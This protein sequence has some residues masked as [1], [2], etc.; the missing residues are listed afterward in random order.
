MT[1]YLPAS[2]TS[3]L[4]HL[5]F[6][7]GIWVTR[8]SPDLGNPDY[9]GDE[10]IRRLFVFAKGYGLKQCSAAAIA[11]YAVARQTALAVSGKTRGNADMAA[12]ADSAAMWTVLNLTERLMPT[13]YG[14]TA[15]V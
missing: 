14:L 4:F 11:A 5:D 9:T 12:W 3:T 8:P 6:V 15:Q 2:L 7:F 10:Q 13:G 1:V